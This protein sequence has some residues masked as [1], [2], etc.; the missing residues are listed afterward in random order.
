[1]LDTEATSR[2]RGP[3]R[4]RRPLA[5]QRRAAVM[6]LLRTMNAWLTGMFKRERA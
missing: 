4:H 1:M 2:R 3:G 5:R 6:T